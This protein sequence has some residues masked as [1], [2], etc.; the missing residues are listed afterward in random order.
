MN[1]GD[2]AAINQVLNEFANPAAQQRL[3]EAEQRA[4]EEYA[5][6]E[7]QQA[8]Q[9]KAEQMKQQQEMADNEPTRQVAMIRR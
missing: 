9:A 3:V 1:S 4:A 5:A 8:E 6:R 2:Q 7:R